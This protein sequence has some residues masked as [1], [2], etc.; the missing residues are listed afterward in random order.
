[1]ARIREN[2]ELINKLLKEENLSPD[3]VKNA[4]LADIAASLAVIADSLDYNR[5]YDKACHEAAE[6]I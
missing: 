2:E 3:G 1:M 6:K 5:S 4:L